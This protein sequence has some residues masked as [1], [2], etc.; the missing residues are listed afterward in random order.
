MQ[1][2]AGKPVRALVIWEPVLWTD[3]ASPSTATLRRVS[4]NRASQFWDKG[5]LISRSMG[6]RDR[7][8]VVWD[9]VAVYP[10]G[11]TWQDG[12]PEA[13]YQGGPVI[14]VTGKARAA[15]GHA[16]KEEQRASEIR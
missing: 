5:R 14:Q 13:L 12:P 11:A 1:E 4:D 7:G 16:L 10:V 2:L 6:E 9:Y 3:W 8:S 15:I